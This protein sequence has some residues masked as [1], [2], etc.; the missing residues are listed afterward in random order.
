MTPPRYRVH[1][2]ICNCGQEARA[3]VNEGWQTAEQILYARPFGCRYAVLYDDTRAWGIDF[4]AIP[5]YSGTDGQF[6]F[7]DKEGVPFLFD[8][9]SLIPFPDVDT[10]VARLT[11][12]YDTSP[13]T[14]YL[15]SQCVTCRHN[16]HTT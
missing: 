6:T 14:M 3:S 11:M 8:D 9:R 15:R 16:I 13:A 2:Y 5:L 12:G 10:A 1:L 7:N 4:H